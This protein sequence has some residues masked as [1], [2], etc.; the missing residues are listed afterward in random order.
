MANGQAFAVMSGVG[1]DATVT[2]EVHARRRGPISRWWYF[3]PTVKNLCFYKWP[4]MSVEVDGR[5]VAEGAAFLV[6]GNMRMYADRLRICANAVPD[7]GLL[8]VCIFTRPGAFHLIGYFLSTRFGRHL[9]RNDVVYRQGTRIVVRP[10]E[11]GVPF[12]VDGD[13][14]GVAPVEYTVRPQA[15]QMFVPVL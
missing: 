5:T 9:Q 12:Q 7:D 3:W 2:G 6:V 11:G 14:V 8:D 10:A 4:H 1:F 13:A 15:V